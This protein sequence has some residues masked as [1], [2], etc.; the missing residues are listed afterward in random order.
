MVS[1]SGQ[2]EV[3]A[4]SDHKKTSPKPKH[5]KNDTNTENTAL[6]LVANS[7]KKSCKKLNGSPQTKSNAQNKRKSTETYQNISV[8]TENIN[9]NIQSNS[10]SSTNN[11]DVKNQMQA[12]TAFNLQSVQNASQSQLLNSFV[13][14]QQ[15]QQLTT[16]SNPN[17]NELV[18][19]MLYQ[20]NVANAFKNSPFLSNL[21]NM[22]M[23]NLMPNFNAASI[24]AQILSN[25]NT[26][27]NNNK[28]NEKTLIKSQSPNDA[29]NAEKSL[30]RLAK[31]VENNQPKDVLDL[32]LPN[33]SRS[34]FDASKLGSNSNFVSYLFDV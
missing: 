3:E 17:T 28:S 33:R 32:S 9:S 22:K 25:N 15:Q 27:S 24:Q 1:L 18:H 30:N 16:L 31:H 8:K 7:A 20:N 21:F 29:L 14:K 26:N 12:S 6:N 10:N 13:L 19:Q 34:S 2:H 4:N 11:E 5:K 23:P